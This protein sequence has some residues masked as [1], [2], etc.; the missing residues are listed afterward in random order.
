[1]NNTVTWLFQAIDPDTGDL[2][3]DLSRGLLPPNN[4]GNAGSGYVTYTVMPEDGVATGTRVKSKARVLFNTAP[5]ED[6]SELVYTIDG[7]APHT[8]LTAMPLAPGGSDYQVQ[9][10]AV[11]DT[12]GSGGKH[13]TVYV[14]ED[15]GDYMIWLRQTHL[16]SAIYQGRPGHKYQFLALA[17][18]NAGNR[19][20]PPPNLMPPDDG[21]KPNLGALPAVQETTQDLGAP[22]PPTD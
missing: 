3:Q 19:E 21:S 6:T 18:D 10:T 5:P 11:D 1:Q 13:V 17:T 15:G 9:W 4:A 2:I 8:T 7:Q 14:S 22:R 20:Q 12:G 16:T